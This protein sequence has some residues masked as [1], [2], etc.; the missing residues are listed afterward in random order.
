MAVRASS[1]FALDDEQK[2]YFYETGFLIVRNLLSSAEVETLR[3]RADDLAVGRIPIPNGDVVDGRATG[4]SRRRMSTMMGGN[5]A[6]QAPEVRLTE[7]HARRGYQVYPIRHRPV[8][9]AEVEAAIAAERAAGAPFA[10]VTGMNHLCDHDEV[11][12]EFGAHPRI[13]AVLREFIGP[14]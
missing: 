11:F 7:N 6:P 13:V 2:A 8:E 12:A 4:V 1:A 3:Q 10:D 14:N 5:P 9:E